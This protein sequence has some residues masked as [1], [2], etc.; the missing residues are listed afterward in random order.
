[1]AVDDEPL[2]RDVERTAL[3]GWIRGR[4][5]QIHRKKRLVCSRSISDSCGS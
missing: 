4:P 1:L 3:D 5:E 2:N